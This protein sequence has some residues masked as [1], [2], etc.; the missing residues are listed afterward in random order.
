M[1]GKSPI[2]IDR[3]VHRQLKQYSEAQQVPL[4]TAASMLLSAALNTQ[5]NALDLIGYLSHARPD[6][7]VCITITADE[8][9][10]A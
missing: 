7:G 6:T 10:T 9:K 5:L 4:T 1:R 8:E 3:R 2:W